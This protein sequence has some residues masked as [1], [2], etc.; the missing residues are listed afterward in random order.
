MIDSRYS[1]CP[2][3]SGPNSIRFWESLAYGSIP[4]LLA[5]T[6]ELPKHELWEKAIIRI[7]EKDLETIPSILEKITS[8]E[9]TEMRKNC[10]T[11]Y[12]H[13]RLNY[14]NNP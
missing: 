11:I 3:G 13:F 1:L 9:E 7:P 6:L 14:M 5:D 8:E 4:I 12:H 10:I 2:S